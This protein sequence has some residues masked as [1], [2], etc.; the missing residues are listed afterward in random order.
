MANSDEA[1]AM[2]E[3][4]NPKSMMTPGVAGGLVM[5]ITNSLISNFSILL[6]V[7]PGISLL[8]SFI[9]GILVLIK[10]LETPLSHRLIYYI[11]NSLVIFAV[12]TGT[13]TVGRVVAERK[14]STTN[15]RTSSLLPNHYI[16]NII[17]K[18]SFAQ[19]G[20]INC[21]N[22]GGFF[23]RWYDEP[24]RMI[25]LAQFDIHERHMKIICNQSKI[26]LIVYVGDIHTTQ[27]GNII[28]FKSEEQIDESRNIVDANIQNEIQTLRN[29]KIL[30]SEDVFGAKKIDF[31]FDDTNFFLFV[32]LRW[33][34]NN[35]GSA[36][37]EVFTEKL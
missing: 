24:R 2:N 29:T 8:F 21:I 12:A 27:K 28:V 1:S 26:N 10:N 5:L 34:P 37:I 9:I 35:D 20:H 25:K 17:V 18:D 6:D 16:A 13:N 11:V 33:A 31:K 22:R 30:A 7:A 36:V 14:S 15:D 3:F 4:F 32:Q 19:D 23:K